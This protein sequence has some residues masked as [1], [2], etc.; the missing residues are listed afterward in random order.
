MMEDTRVTSPTCPLHACSD[1]D[2]LCTGGQEQQIRSHQRILS[3]FSRFIHRFSGRRRRDERRKCEYKGDRRY[4]DINSCDDDHQVPVKDHPGCDNKIISSSS[5]PWRECRL[6][7]SCDTS[8]SSSHSPVKSSSTSSHLS[9]AQ[10]CLF[11]LV[12]VILLSCADACSSRSTPRPRPPSPTMRPNITFQTYACPPAYAA[13]YC[14][15]GATCFT[16]K[17][18][19][20]I[21]YN[22]ECADGFMGQRCEFKDLDGTYVSSS[23]RLRQSAAAASLSTV[24]SAGTNVMV[25]ALLIIFG[26]VLAALV[27]TKRRSKAK[28][29]KIEEFR[30]QTLDQSFDERRDSVVYDGD[31]GHSSDLSQTPSSS[32]VSSDELPNDSCA[33]QV[34]LQSSSVSPPSSSLLSSLSTRW[35]RHSSDPEDAVMKGTISFVLSRTESNSLDYRSQVKAC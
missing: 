23:E 19:R 28:M 18:G 9:Q 6:S 14:L 21:L 29:R 34:S 8:P 25:G 16:V 15:N 10:L 31:S 30:Q 17:I 20:S 32:P 12:L 26:T 2:Q 24:S 5:H 27:F 4:D 3:T 35:S 33:Y 7:S 11:Y 13:W 22:C 1:C